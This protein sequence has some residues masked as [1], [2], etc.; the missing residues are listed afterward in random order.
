MCI[1]SESEIDEII[2][3]HFHNKTGNNERPIFYVTYGPPGS[4]KGFVI[5]KFFDCA[6]EFVHIDVDS[7]VQTKIKVNENYWEWRGHADEISD[8]ILEK[9]K[10]ERYHIVWETTG[11]DITYASKIME[12]MKTNG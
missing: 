10:N 12:K 2:S 6:T 8:L 7:I 4:G 3:V 9:A 1:Y 11:N 5:S